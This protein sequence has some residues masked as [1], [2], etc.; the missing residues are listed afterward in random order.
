MK[1]SFRPIGGRALDPG[2]A[3]M[4][5]TAR[6]GMLAGLN[7]QRPALSRSGFFIDAAG[8]VLTTTDILQSCSRL[9]IDGDL[10][11]SVGLTDAAAGLAVLVPV[12]RLAPPDVAAFQ[13]KT[14]AAGSEVAV[15]GYPYEDRLSAPTVTFGFVA[16]EA[17]LD[18]EQGVKRLSLPALPGDA[19]GPVV[20]AT[21]A[22]VGMML[23]R[24]ADAVRQL[25]PDVAFAVSAP[26]IVARLQAGNIPAR[27][28]PA[29]G[30]LPPEDLA[31]QAR[32]MT[33]LVSCW[34]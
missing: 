19:G 10:T 2:A 3:P 20:D 5:A 22:V 14:E 34:K 24:R 32:G 28:S 17:G 31:R 26:A 7:V 15:A 8:T 4:T 18:G 25:P 9:S 33:V 11:M 12:R 21:G 23:P 29:R 27:V 13:G 16:A 1:A 30:A 6:D